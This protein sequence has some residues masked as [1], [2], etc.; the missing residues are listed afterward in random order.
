[1]LNNFLDLLTQAVKIATQ[2]YPSSKFYEADGTTSQGLASAENQVDTWRFVFLGPRQ[3]TVWTTLYLTYQNG[4]F[5]DLILKDEF[6]LGDAIIPLP[7]PM[8]LAKAIQL[9][10]SAGHSSPFKG[11]NLRQ[12]L[13]PGNTEPFYIFSDSSSGSFI[14]VGVK[15]GNV[16]GLNIDGSALR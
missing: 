13:S 10:N 3:Q 14:F 2:A 6:F 5:A 11:V 1:M 4:N 7:I 9:K 12:P 15:S 16:T 8:G